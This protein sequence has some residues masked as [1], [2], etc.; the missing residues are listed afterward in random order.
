MT[1][2]WYVNNGYA[3]S[4]NIE[5]S[6]IDRAER[7]A[8]NAYVKPIISTATGTEEDVIPLLADISFAI[9]MQRSLKVTRKGTKIKT[10]ANSQ[11]AD[12]TATLR[13]QSGIAQMA[14]AR[15]RELDIADNPDAKVTDIAKIYFRT[16][17][18]GM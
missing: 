10:D 16:Y 12:I 14:V 7:D 9:I 15:L 5:Q 1:K 13:E 2:E 8:L 4:V 3:M 18:L 17:L 6:V 11:Q